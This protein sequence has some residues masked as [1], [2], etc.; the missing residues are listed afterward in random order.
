M[1][2]DTRGWD[3][4]PEPEPEDEGEHRRSVPHVAWRPLAWIAAFIWLLV[5]AAELDG[6]AGYGVFLLAIALGSWRLERWAARWEVGRA[7]DSG[8]WY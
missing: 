4:G 3:P 6:F 7:G 1:L 5:L 8:A 2:I